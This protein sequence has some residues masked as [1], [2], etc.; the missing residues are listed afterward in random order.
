M[1]ALSVQARGRPGPGLHTELLSGGVNRLG[2]ALNKCHSQ[3]GG[4]G[5]APLP[6]SVQIIPL[7]LVGQIQLWPAAQVEGKP[8]GGGEAL[9]RQWCSLQLGFPNALMSRTPEIDAK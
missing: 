3:W 6:G 5:R 2:P 1:A 7:H 8:G 4:A 9:F